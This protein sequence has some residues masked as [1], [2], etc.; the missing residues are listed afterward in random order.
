ML[1][2]W[3][4]NPADVHTLLSVNGNVAIFNGTSWT[5]NV[6]GGTS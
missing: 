6:H 2:L 4:F 1:G 5:A 3:G